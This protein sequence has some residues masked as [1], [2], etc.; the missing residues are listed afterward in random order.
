MSEYN[1]TITERLVKTLIIEAESIEEAI[2]KAEHMV[3]NSEVILDADDFLD[4]DFEC[5]LANR[6]E[7]ENA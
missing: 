3:N 5:E 7:V 4:R 1:V 6:T 2:C